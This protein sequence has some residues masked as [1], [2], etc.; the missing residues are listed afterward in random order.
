MRNPKRN[1]SKLHNGTELGEPRE[2]A[3]QN[4]RGPM[5]GKNK[6][7]DGD[8]DRFERRHRSAMRKR[9]ITLHDVGDTDAADI[10]DCAFTEPTDDD[11]KAIEEEGEEGK[12]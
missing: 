3:N 7:S 5:S 10:V 11:L 8:G 1:L 9:R 6:K 2:S 12:T 4:R